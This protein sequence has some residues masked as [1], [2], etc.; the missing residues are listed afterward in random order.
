M[1]RDRW[2][3]TLVELLV[4]VA[5]I[6]VL[7][8]LLLPLLSRARYSANLLTC[9]NNLRSIGQGL[10]TYSSSANGF[11][12]PQCY[13]IFDFNNPQLPT[14]NY[15]FFTG[16]MGLGRMR[17]FRCP[18]VEDQWPYAGYY[19]TSWSDTTYQANGVILSRNMLTIPNPSTIVMADEWPY[20]FDVAVCRPINWTL[21]NS[22][23]NTLPYWNR[24]LKTDNF[25]YWH[26]FWY[27]REYYSNVHES[28]GNIVYMDGHTEYRKVQ[29]LRSGEFGLFPDELY[30]LTNSAGPDTM[31]GQYYHPAF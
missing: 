31:P 17:K 23:S 9:N 27:G 30:S 3:F 18:V 7:V 24:P 6:A 13:V 29:T 19:P 1:K 4:V 28:G 16:A 5:V 26:N 14:S 11:L 15:N 22:W 21:A 10:Y 12:P 20:R 8:S 2:G 25:A